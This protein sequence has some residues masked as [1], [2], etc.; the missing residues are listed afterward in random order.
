MG[1]R[2][3]WKRLSYQFF[4]CCVSQETIV[5][6]IAGSWIWRLQLPPKYRLDLNSIHGGISQTTEIFV[7]TDISEK[8]MKPMF[9]D[10]FI[11]CIEVVER[12]EVPRTVSTMFRCFLSLQRPYSDGHICCLV[13]Y[14]LLLTCLFSLVL[15]QRICEW[16]SERTTAE[17]DTIERAD[18]YTRMWWGGI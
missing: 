17:F 18:R 13:T 10:S 2:W 1:D 11:I 15:R 12:K 16:I 14:R 3:H 6:Q 7:H 9:P 8:C 4:G 5:K